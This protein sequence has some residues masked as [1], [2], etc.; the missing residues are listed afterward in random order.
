MPQNVHFWIQV[1]SVG[2]NVKY[3]GG[4]ET[5]DGGTNVII[6]LYLCKSAQVLLDLAA[7]TAIYIYIA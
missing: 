6:F 1:N 3:I 4:V 2:K 5:L 7:A